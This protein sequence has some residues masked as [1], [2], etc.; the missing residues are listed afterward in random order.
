MAQQVGFASLAEAMV[1]G[2]EESSPGLEEGEVEIV[3]NHPVDSTTELVAPVDLIIHANLYQR[4]PS[5]FDHLSNVKLSFLPTTYSP[6]RA[7]RNLQY[8]AAHVKHP[9]AIL[10]IRFLS[11]KDVAA[12]DLDGALPLFL[13]EEGSVEHLEPSVVA[14]ILSFGLPADGIYRLELKNVDNEIQ[15]SI[16]V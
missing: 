2:Q 15:L 10:D 13:M 5:A 7:K 4:L 11:Y 12:L 9:I 1:F 8:H 14:T 6:D 16:F 3:K